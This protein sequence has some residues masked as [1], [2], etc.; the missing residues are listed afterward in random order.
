MEFANEYWFPSSVDHAKWAV[1]EKKEWTCIGDINRT[2]CPSHYTKI[3]H[4][5]HNNH[6]IIYLTD[7]DIPFQKSQFKRGGGTMCFHHAK[8]ANQFRSIIKTKEKCNKGM[9]CYNIT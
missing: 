8:V 2:V 9:P 6:N 4:I 5:V 1:T 7:N 3:I